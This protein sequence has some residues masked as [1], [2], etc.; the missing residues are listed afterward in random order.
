MEISIISFGCDDTIC[1][2][3]GQWYQLKRRPHNALTF[4]VLDLSFVLAT[5]KYYPGRDDKRRGSYG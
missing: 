4:S 1:K 3:K 2:T 5:A